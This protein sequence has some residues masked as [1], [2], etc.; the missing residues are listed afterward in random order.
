MTKMFNTKPILI[1]NFCIFFILHAT[2]A[3]AA[4]KIRSAI[5]AGTNY[6]Y[7]NDIARYYGMNYLPASKAAQLRSQYSNLYFAVDKRQAKVNDVVTHLSMA[8]TSLGSELLLSEIDFRLL[9][10][11]IMRSR[12]LPKCNPRRILIDPGHG[13]RDRGTKGRHVIEK[14]LV[15]EIAQRLVKVLRSEGYFAGLTRSDDRALSLQQRP[16]YAAEWRADLFVSLHANYAANAQVKGLET[17]LLSPANTAST[18]SNTVDKKTSTGNRFDK[19]NAR[20]AYDIQK[21]MVTA[22]GAVDRGIKHARFLVL[23]DAP[24]AA[25][26]VEVGFLSNYQE[27]KQLNSSS[28]Q[29]KIVR[30]IA[31]GIIQ[32]Q[33][34]CVSG[35]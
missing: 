11:P 8:P 19:L 26:L 28:Y 25:V 5:I 13:G 35:S 1:V 20:L 15:L 4:F 7:L 21:N 32:F 22:T 17:F 31:D 33:R 27:E 29:K 16:V 10:D 12:A 6:V 23:R 34:R 9:L 24:C 3:E 2:D 18:Y 14:D 30:G